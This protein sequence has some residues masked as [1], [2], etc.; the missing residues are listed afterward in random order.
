LFPDFAVVAADPDVRPLLVWSIVICDEAQDRGADTLYE[1]LTRSLNA[2][3][4]DGLMLHFGGSAPSVLRP[5]LQVAQVHRA[6]DALQIAGETV[7]Q[8]SHLAGGRR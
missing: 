2:V 6:T 4:A 3:K 7:R 1:A 5:G 8:V